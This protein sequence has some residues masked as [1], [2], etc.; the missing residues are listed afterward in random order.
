M[1]LDSDFYKNNK[2]NMLHCFDEAMKQFDDEELDIDDCYEIL[3]VFDNIVMMSGFNISPTEGYISI[4][5]LIKK[6]KDIEMKELREKVQD[7]ILTKKVYGKLFC[8]VLL[9]VMYNSHILKT[10]QVL[11]EFVLPRLDPIVQDRTH[12]MVV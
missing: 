1:F 12:R 2:V 11:K 3:Q 6:N 7:F 8:D 4:N 10:K 5:E 9:D